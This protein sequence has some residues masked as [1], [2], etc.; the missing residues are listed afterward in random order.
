MKTIK[1]TGPVLLLVLLLVGCDE[2]DD[3][4]D[5]NSNADDDSP[6][7]EVASE[8][9]K[10]CGKSDCKANL[11]AG[12]A[13]L[14]AGDYQEAFEQYRC[15]DTVEAAAGAALTKFAVMM[16]SDAI[17]NLLKDFGSDTP[18]QF[19]DIIGPNGALYQ[20]GAYS[21]GEGNVEIPGASLAGIPIRIDK[22]NSDEPSI[23][24]ETEGETVSD[25]SDIE[26]EGSIYT[27]EMDLDLWIE[28][29]PLLELQSG[30]MI[31]IEYNCDTGDDYEIA[32]PDLGPLLDDIYVSFDME[33]ATQYLEC[34]IFRYY[35][36]GEEC[37]TTVGSVEI[38]TMDGF[39][40][41]AEIR[42]TDIPLRCYTESEDTALIYFS[43]TFQGTYHET[44][45]FETAHMHPLFDDPESEFEDIPDGLTVNQL[46]EQLAPLKD[47]FEEAACFAA[48]ADNGSKGA[49]FMFPRELTGTVD[50][51]LTTRDTKL[52]A[53]AFYASAAVI[54]MANSYD[55]PTRLGQMDDMTDVELAAEIN[56]NIGSLKSEHQMDA[57]LTN[58]QLAAEQLVAAVAAKED[59]GLLPSNPYTAGGEALMAKYAQFFQESLTNG[60]TAF[61]ETNPPVMMDLKALFTNPPDPSQFTA[62][63]LVVET[64][65]G[66][67]EWIEGVEL[68]FQ[69]LLA[70]AIPNFDY[71]MEDYDWGGD[72]WEAEG[73][74]AGEEWY[75][76]TC[77]Y[78]MCFGYGNSVDSVGSLTVSSSDNNSSSK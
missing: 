15:G 11:S 28:L 12:K 29:E 10:T 19:S 73:E 42:L 74:A 61:P 5:Q 64:D 72:A 44:D 21:D 23:R 50:L 8:A 70:E 49:V 63:P 43:G 41:P 31:P 54:Q 39:G 7:E 14:V 27:R 60:L 47:G 55:V 25:L 24:G 4:A 76:A 20:L 52:L 75:Y 22:D 37:P 32:E 36:T 66:D 45:D 2:V 57:A 26:I 59:L 40:K 67:Y 71:D 48:A 6:V 77:E 46:I 56:A 68:F 51:P 18:F 38:V 17:N 9:G 62:D 35:Y 78:F 58:M 33:S 65:D 69:E 16:E 1:L 13:A 53:T 34:S 3:N 30:D